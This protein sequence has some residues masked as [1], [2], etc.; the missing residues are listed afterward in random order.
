MGCKELLALDVCRRSCAGASKPSTAPL[1]LVGP[2][3]PSSPSPSHK[4]SRS[5]HIFCTTQFQSSTLNIFFLLNGPFYNLSCAIH[6]QGPDQRHTKVQGLQHSP[7][8]SRAHKS[9]AGSVARAEAA[10]RGGLEEAILVDSLGRPRTHVRIARGAAL[11]IARRARERTYPEFFHAPRCR[12]VVLAL[13]IGGR[14]LT[15]RA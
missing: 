7:Y 12:L 5:S 4:T 11:H 9:K 15:S 2:T 6:V 1:M 13:E 3:P 8:Q 10:G 14:G